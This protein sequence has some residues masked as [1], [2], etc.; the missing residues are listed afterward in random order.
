MDFGD[1]LKRFVELKEKHKLDNS[2]GGNSIELQE[3][4]SLHKNFFDLYMEIRLRT[5]KDPG[6]AFNFD[7]WIMDEYNQMMDIE[8]LLTDDVEN[9]QEY[10]ELDFHM[11]SFDNLGF[12]NEIVFNWHRRILNALEN[13]NYVMS[14]FYYTKHNNNNKAL[15]QHIALKSDTY[16]FLNNKGLLNTGYCPITGEKIDNS[17]NY[18]IYNRKVFLSKKGIEVCESIDRKSWTGKNMDYDTFQQLKTETRRK[19]KSQV[20]LITLILIVLSLFFSWI[21]VSPTGF[22]S[23]IGFLIVAVILF[24]VIGWLF[25]FLFDLFIR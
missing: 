5:G 19:T 24:Y 10:S 14:D 6:K 3:Y 18:N 11:Q 16:N 15:L 8:N 9:E 1:K 13:D 23:F 12:K 22:F 25:N 4:N 20:Q 21:I 7:K 2:L 17:M